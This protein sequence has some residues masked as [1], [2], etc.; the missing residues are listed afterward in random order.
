MNGMFFCF[1]IA[2]LKYKELAI[3]PRAE[4]EC[5]DYVNTDGKK[6]ADTML[7]KGCVREESN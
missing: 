4:A 2:T 7:Q 1:L 5:I 6:D 3:L